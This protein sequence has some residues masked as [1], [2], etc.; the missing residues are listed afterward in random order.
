MR[1]WQALSIAKYQLCRALHRFVVQDV[2]LG[3]AYCRRPRR[4]ARDQAHELCRGFSLL[5]GLRSLRTS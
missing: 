1:S 2:V 3:M 5:V 4:L